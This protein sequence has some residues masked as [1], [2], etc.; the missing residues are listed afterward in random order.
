VYRGQLFYIGGE[1]G[2][3]TFTQNEAFDPR[4]A[5]WTELAPL[6]SGR[7]GTGAAVI[8]DALYLPAGGP[9]TGGSEQ[10]TTLYIYT[11]P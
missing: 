10:S 5:R 8:A 6:P 4:T 9:V 11:Q 2:G 1:R 7:H 3:G